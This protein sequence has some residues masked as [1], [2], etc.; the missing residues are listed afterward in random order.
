MRICLHWLKKSL[1]EI[2][3]FCAVP[4]FQ[5]SCLSY[6]LGFRNIPGLFIKTSLSTHMGTAGH[7]RENVKFSKISRLRPRGKFSTGEGTK[8][9]GDDRK[10]LHSCFLL[11]GARGVRL[12]SYLYFNCWETR[13]RLL[14]SWEGYQKLYKAI[15]WF[16]DNVQ[17]DIFVAGYYDWI[18]T[19]NYWTDELLHAS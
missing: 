6:N 14:N 16:S 4:V 1:T 19:K 10:T 2:F 12:F 5:N 18:K 17:A 3:N 13:E 9:T 11:V 15:N 7:T 8:P